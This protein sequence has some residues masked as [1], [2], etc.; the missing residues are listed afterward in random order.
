MRKKDFPSISAQ[1]AKEVLGIL[2]NVELLVSGEKNPLYNTADA[3]A[4]QEKSRIVFKF[5]EKE[6]GH[7][8][9]TTMADIG[10]AEGG[11]LLRRLYLLDVWD[12]EVRSKFQLNL[13]FAWTS[14]DRFCFI[15]EALGHR[16]LSEN[17]KKRLSNSLLQTGGNGSRKTGCGKEFFYLETNRRLCI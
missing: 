5:L 6:V 7:G 11:S 4:Q 8:L 15:R 1:E 10:K 3:F 2:G 13:R 12:E 9:W 17:W 16:P 14:T